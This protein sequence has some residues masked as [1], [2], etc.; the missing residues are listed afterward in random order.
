MAS[1]RLSRT[2]ALL[3][4]PVLGT[5]AL[6]EA[7]LVA[8]RRTAPLRVL[9][10]SN[11][12]VG[13]YLQTVGTI[14]AVLLAFVVYVV[15]TQ[16]NEVRT[17]VD[18]EANEVR[19]LHRTVGA[20]PD[21]TRAEVRAA[22]AR[23]VRAVLDEEWESMRRN[24][25]GGAL[26][27]CSALLEEA[28]AA[29]GRFDGERGCHAALFS[30]AL[31]RFNDLSDARVL[32]L[33]AASQR[34]PAALRILLYVGATALIMS[35]YLFGVGSFAVHAL[36]TGALAGSLSHLLVLVEDLDHP[37]AGNWQVSRVPFEQLLGAMEDGA[38]CEAPPAA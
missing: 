11:D 22:L 13:N 3:L 21:P 38:A 32:R 16:F 27:R 2:L 6:A 30:E 26:P 19:D 15:W 36:L 20:L 31:Q 4:P 24:G 35:M 10:R 5:M 33:S 29:L 17:L 14:Y 34:I 18:R 9:E 25:G 8:A 37:F 28:W 1:P 23:Y 7:G 12:V